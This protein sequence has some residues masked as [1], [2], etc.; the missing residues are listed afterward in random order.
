MTAIR[1]GGALQ[2]RITAV[3]TADATQNGYQT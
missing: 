1:F 3:I 2:A